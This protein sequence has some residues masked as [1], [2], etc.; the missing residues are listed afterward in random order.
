MV[1]LQL[2]SFAR[3]RCLSFNHRGSVSNRQS[4][5][6]VQNPAEYVF[7]VET[8]CGFTEGLTVFS[9]PYSGG[10]SVEGNISA[11][12][13]GF[14]IDLVNLNKIVELHQDEWVCIL[15]AGKVY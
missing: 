1:E 6:Q 14:S 4:I 2:G 5:Y 8:P 15:L 11:P 12:Y 9:V 7:L 3:G 10:S 13:G